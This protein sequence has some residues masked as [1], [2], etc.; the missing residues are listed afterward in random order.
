MRGFGLGGEAKLRR[1]PKPTPK[2]SPS[3]RSA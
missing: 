2:K 1:S 3:G